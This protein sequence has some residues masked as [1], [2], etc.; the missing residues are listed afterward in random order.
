MNI[1]DEHF[2]NNFIKFYERYI[3]KL[4]KIGA[5]EYQGSCPF[6]EDKHPSFSLKNS[7]GVHFCHGCHVKGNAISFYAQIHNL[8]TKKD[9]RKIMAAI[10]DEFG[11]DNGNKE[12]SD[13]EAVYPYQDAEG[14]VL[15]EICRMPKKV[16]RARQLDKNGKYIWNVKGVEP[17]LYNLPEVIKAHEVLI[18]EGEKDVETARKLTGVATCNPFGAGKWRDS[19]SEYLKGKNVVIIADNDEPGVKHAASV[20]QSLSG[21]AQSLKI[22][23]FEDMPEGSDLTDFIN[24]YPNMMEGAERLSIMIEGA[25]EVQD[26]NTNTDPLRFIN[27]A[28][29]IDTEPE[30]VDPILID[31]FDRGDKVVVIGSLKMKKTFFL[32]E[33]ALC[34]ASGRPF[35]RWD[36]AKQRRIAII[37]FEIQKHHK[38][39][40]IKRLAKALDITPSDLEDRLHILN[41][42]GLNITGVEGLEKITPLI[43]EKNPDLIIIDPLYKLSMGVENAAEDAKIILNAFDVLVEKTGAAILYAHHDPKGSPGDRDIRDRGAG[44]NVIGRDYDACF[45]ITAHATEPDA[46]IIE[47][48][49][50]NYAPQEDFVIEWQGDDD[51]Y[52][53]VEREDFMPEKKTSKTRAEKPPLSSYLPIAVPILGDEEM[54]IAVFKEAFKRQTGLGDHRIRDF[55]LWATAGGNPPLITT[56]VRGFGINKKWVKVRTTIDDED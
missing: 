20:A 31:T 9:F 54:E 19:F 1:I 45:T 27:A 11:I 47:T 3:P 15:Y 55:M 38:H 40:R 12:S 26:R 52:K 18:V 16:F 49:L 53:F 36:N 17:V 56:N 50:R 5:N 43:M 51:G 48:L 8:D 2:S 21:K 24:Q 46:V 39:K 7:N 10:C 30:D 23:R 34:L 35:L 42:R 4:K 28:E 13:P 44:S 37:Q 29:W 14:N 25:A 41:A 32:D 6:H 22:I 33:M